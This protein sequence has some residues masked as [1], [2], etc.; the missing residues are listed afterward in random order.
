MIKRRSTPRPKALWTQVFPSQAVPPA[1]PM[2]QKKTRKRVR[3][4][5]KAL[6]SQRAKYRVSVAAWKAKAE[7]RF[8]KFPGC[9]R[10][11]ED[12]HH[13]RGRRGELLL[14]ERFWFPVCRRHHDWIRDNPTEARKIGL[15]PPVGQYD[16]TP[17]SWQKTLDR[18]KAFIEDGQ[19]LPSDRYAN[20]VHPPG[21]SGDLAGD[22][23]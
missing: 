9:T 22:G 12:C 11:T 4:M 5:S 10:K 3:P 15:L 14:D 17:E 20:G 18:K 8:C 6:T 19:V 16:T 23:G 13:T 7:N 1:A 21:C 2:S